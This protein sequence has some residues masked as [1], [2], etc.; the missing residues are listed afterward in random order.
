ME[1]Q[2]NKREREREGKT[3][4]KNKIWNQTENKTES[5]NEGEQVK[6]NKKNRQTLRLVRSVFKMII[7]S[8]NTTKTMLRNYERR[9]TDN[10][11]DTK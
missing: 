1:E 6:Q 3:H 11:N 5:I 7:V 10:A 2:V 4:Q 8:A 9:Q